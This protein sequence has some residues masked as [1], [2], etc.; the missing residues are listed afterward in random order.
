MIRKANFVKNVGFL[1]R[2][3][4]LSAEEFKDYWMNVHVPMVRQR[5]PGLVLYTGSFP[6]PTKSMPDAPLAKYDCLVEM[7]F[8]NIDAMH[9]ALASPGFLSED[10]QVSSAKLMDVARAESLVVEEY[11]VDLS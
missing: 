4:D 11:V 10:R 1:R 7:G 9:K 8:E 2:N 6:L 5:L 3:P